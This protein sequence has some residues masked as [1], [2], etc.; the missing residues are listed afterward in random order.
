MYSANLTQL[1]A[2]STPNET[3]RAWDRCLGYPASL[4]QDPLND[5]DP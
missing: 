5:S 1:R 2:Y 3:R 4:L